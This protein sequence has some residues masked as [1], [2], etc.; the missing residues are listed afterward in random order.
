MHEWNGQHEL[1]SPQDNSGYQPMDD[2]LK[3]KVT[4]LVTNLFVTNTKRVNKHLQD[5]VFNSSLYHNVQ[6]TN[7]RFFPQHKTLKNF[8]DKVLAENL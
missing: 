1:I 3:K 2:E 6:R 8:I 7:Q 4:S 5:F